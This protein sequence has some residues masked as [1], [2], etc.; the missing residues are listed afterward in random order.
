MPFSDEWGVVAGAGVDR[1]EEESG[2]DATR[3]VGRR[4]ARRWR[5]VALILILLIAVMLAAAWLQRRTIARSFV[6]RELARRGVPARYE[7]EQLSPWRQRLTNVSIGDPRNPDLTADWIELRTALTPW[8]AEVLVAKAGTVRL[9]GRIVDGALS[10][11][12]LDRL[13]PAPSGKPFS[14]PQLSVEVAD[15][16]LALDS[17]SGRIHI[18]LSGK[19]LLTDG[20]AGAAWARADRLAASGCTLDRVAARMRL[21]I[22]RGA[23]SVEGPVDA[24]AI[25][26][27]TTRLTRPHVELTADLDASLA[28]WSGRATLGAARLNAPFARLDQTT[29]TIDFAGDRARTQG[30]VALR[31]GT[32]AAQGIT[33]ASATLAGRYSV[34][35]ATGFDGRIE[36]AGAALPSPML[37][38]IA[39]YGNTGQ[40]TPI[41]PLARQF[42][43]A[44]QQAGRGFGGSADIDLR[45]G[46]DGTSL[47][48]KTLDLAT[49][50]G[51][52]L[53][54][55]GGTGINFGLADSAVDLAGRLSLSG[56]GMPDVSVQLTRQPGSAELRGTGVVRPFAAGGASLALSALDFRVRGDAGEVRTVATLSGPLSGGRIDGLS[57]P[58]AARW[59]GPMLAVNSECQTVSF[60]RIAAAGMTLNADRVTLCPIGPAM[61]QWGAQGLTGGVRTSALK[62]AGSMGESPLSLSA[63]AARLNLTEGTFG[64]TGAAVR[65]G[66]DQPT[67]LDIGQL[68]G[69][70]RSTLGGEFEA[71]GGRIGPVPLIL[72][73]GKGTWQVEQGVLSLI[74]GFRLT[75][76]EP[77]A[78]FEPLAATNA[79]LSLRDGTV[80]AQAELV[81][82]KRP[83]PVGK[84]TVTHH[85]DTA[86]GE[87]LL[88]VPGI[89]FAVDGL[90]PTDLTSL[91]YGVI[92]DVQG[93][94]AGTGRFAWSGD[95]VTSTGRFTATDVDLA[96]AFGPVQGLTTQLDFVDLLAMRTAPGQVAQVDEINPGVPVRDGA[97]RYQILD[98]RR[99][100]VE[101]ARWP[102]AG[103]ELILDPTTLD[104]NE[105]GER[106]MTFHVK[107]VDAALFLK[108]MAFDNLDATGTFDGTLPMIFDANG[109]RIEGGELRARAGGTIAYVGEISQRNLGLWGNMAFQA[110]KSLNYANLT[111]RMN[112]PLAGEMITDI[113]FSGV[114]QGKGTKSNFLIRR[115]AKLPFV[116]N[117]RINAPFRQLLDSV[118]SWYDPKRLIERNLPTLLEEQNRAEEAQKPIVQPLESVPVP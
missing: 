17:G 6:D 110:L 83:V 32:L 26:C 106:R 21:R 20:F 1:S 107:G 28:R 79:R 4:P 12:Y 104:F 55:G 16:Q 10:L 53:R 18:G 112:G 81:G 22:R 29:G 11:G 60:S 78:R 59:D 36:L 38:R 86:K 108:E 62:L 33:A 46:G 76:A 65:L 117:V 67:Q 115:L 90:Q 58:L 93:L 66:A 50:S 69:G 89:R 71:L 102:F 73:Q 116:F 34:G 54:F 35:T 75:D 91:T 15:A 42:A 96:A 74:G 19:G 13:M 27:G 97:F 7:I 68:T 43:R 5:R 113:S 92:A 3:L 101:G 14:L 87:A 2:A 88:D 57:M 30:S 70:Y 23:P 109:G 31:S 103:G 41:A 56:G 24:A 39:A 84:V 45:T 85:L 100:R 52:R 37:G 49:R 94:V 80:E 51:A 82:T 63:D 64:I 77:T 111:I 72:S 114:S 95:G 44:L 25:A 98:T 40:G 99:V 105:A 118:Q 47:H 9:R 48:L 61:V 8:R